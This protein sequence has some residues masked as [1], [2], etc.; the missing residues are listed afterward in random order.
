MIA[1]VLKTY[2]TAQ[3]GKQSLVRVWNGTVT[4]GMTLN[5]TRV[6]GVYRLMGAEQ[7]KCADG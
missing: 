2:Y 5:D 3:G 7:K 6:G 4:E 1:Q